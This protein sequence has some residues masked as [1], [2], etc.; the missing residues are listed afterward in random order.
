MQAAG[1]NHADIVR[2]LL[3]KKADINAR[4]GIDMSALDI[5]VQNG[6]AEIVR[7]LKEAGAK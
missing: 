6:Y 7:I 5:A 3:E 1:N 2:L 4:N